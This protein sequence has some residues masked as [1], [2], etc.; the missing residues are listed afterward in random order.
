MFFGILFFLGLALICYA[1][2]CFTKVEKKS[3][4]GTVVPS[5]NKAKNIITIG[6]IFIVVA[7][8]GL[9]VEDLFKP[10]PADAWKTKNNRTMAYTMMQE[11]VKR[12]LVSPASAK[13]QWITEPDCIIEKDGFDYSV[14]SWVDSQNAFGAMI[15]TRFSGVVRQIDKDN[16]ELLA[17][18]FEE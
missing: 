16:W 11:F 8:I 1:L 13:F 5:R 15:R 14:S 10:E 12:N 18:E 2:Y 4:T 3:E 17:L 7:G 9:F 6:I